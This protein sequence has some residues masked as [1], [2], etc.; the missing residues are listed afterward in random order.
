MPLLFAILY[1][2]AGG[3]SYGVYSIKKSF[4]VPGLI[5]ISLIAFVFLLLAIKFAKYLISKFG[6]KLK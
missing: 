5:V 3:A 2:F 6:K 4:T 1:I